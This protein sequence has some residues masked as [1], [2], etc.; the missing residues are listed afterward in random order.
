M[1]L[2]WKILQR[3]IGSVCMF[4]AKVAKLNSCCLTTAS[5]V[6]ERAKETDLG[7]LTL[8]GSL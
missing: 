1:T 8:D 4:L 2:R 3:Y 5:K 6:I 7:I